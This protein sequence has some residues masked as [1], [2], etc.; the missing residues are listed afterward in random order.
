MF[1]KIGF[2]VLT[3]IV[4]A[5]IGL[6]LK[7]NPMKNTGAMSWIDIY[8]DAPAETIGFLNENFGIHVT[9]SSVTPTGQTY[10]VIKAK[11]QLWPFAG[12]MENPIQADGVKAPAGTTIYLTVK[13]YDAAHEKAIASGAIP[14]ATHMKVEGMYFGFYMIPGGVGIGIVQ[15]E[16]VKNEAK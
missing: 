6:F 11:G 3:G 16:N 13:D 14:H 2:W 8:S 15:Y 7:T 12:I 1:Y 9:K 10:N 4:L 5:C